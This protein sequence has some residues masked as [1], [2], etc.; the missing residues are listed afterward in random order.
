MGTLVTFP[1]SLLF[2][3]DQG[4]PHDPKMEPRTEWKCDQRAHSLD[5]NLFNT[6]NTK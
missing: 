6:K 5:L 1:F 2:H 4:E 3:S